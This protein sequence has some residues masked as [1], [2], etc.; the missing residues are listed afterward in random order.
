MQA[1]G[2]VDIVLKNEQ[3]IGGGEDER[4]QT[5]SQSL[6][7]NV[8]VIPATKPLTRSVDTTDRPLRVAA[9]CRVSTEMEEQLNSYAVQTSHYTE[10]IKNTPNWEFAGI[11]AD[12][13]I[14]GTGVKNR[15]EFNRMIRCCKR[16]RID[17]ILT[18]SVSRFARNTLDCIKYI[19]TLERDWC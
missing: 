9:Y 4:S 5:A 15:D 14:S 18:K 12:K 10:K 19:R 6:N 2:K 11:F 13:G 16:G 1:G 8:R 17:M 3:R 7:K